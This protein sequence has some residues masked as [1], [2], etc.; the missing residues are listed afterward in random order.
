V[1]VDVSELRDGQ[2]TVYARDGSR[3][4][5]HVND[6]AITGLR[7]ADNL[8]RDV[9]IHTVKRLSRDGK[10]YVTEDADRMPL[11]R[12]GAIGIAPPFVPGDCGLVYA[13][14]ES[15][16]VCATTAGATVTPPPPP[17]ETILVK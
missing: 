9:P 12:D 16:W 13:G 5:A 11:R 10:T 6:K 15:W 17:T 2:H 7:I 3:L 1:T 8:N 14:S 4:I